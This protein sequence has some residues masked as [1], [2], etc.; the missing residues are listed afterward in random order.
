M[1]P[2]EVQ[3]LG[4]RK[5]AVENAKAQLASIHG[6]TKVTTECIKLLVEAGEFEEAYT[7]EEPAE[8]LLIALCKVQLAQLRMAEQE[9]KA[10]IENLTAFIKSNESPLFGATLI[11]PTNKNPG[12]H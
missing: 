1:N 10:A 9:G 5:Q 3:A 2:A 6:R 4:Q 8:P 7:G 12:R 11:P